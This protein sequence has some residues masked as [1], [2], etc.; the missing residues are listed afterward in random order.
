MA[1]A[2]GDA[3]AQEDSSKRLSDGQMNENCSVDSGED[4]HL[5][6]LGVAAGL[7]ASYIASSV[8]RPKMKFSP[9]EA[10]KCP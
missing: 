1:I 2:H 3:I 4:I 8:S 10:Q 6:S 9:R 5:C 7:A